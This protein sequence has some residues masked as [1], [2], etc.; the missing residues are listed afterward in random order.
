MR[1]PDTDGGG[2]GYSV[3]KEKREEVGNGTGAG[4]KTHYMEQFKP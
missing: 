1:F 2:W 3:G 4:R